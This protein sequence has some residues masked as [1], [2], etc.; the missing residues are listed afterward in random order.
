[1]VFAFYCFA[2]LD[3]MGLLDAV[4]KEDERNGWRE[5]IWE[6]QIGK[7]ALQSSIRQLLWN[8]SSGLRQ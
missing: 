1:M 8:P 2:A 4:T 3:V 7:I 5:W 6:Q